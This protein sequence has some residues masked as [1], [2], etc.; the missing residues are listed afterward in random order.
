[1]SMEQIC[2]LITILVYLAGMLYIGFYCTKKGGSGNTGDFYLGGRQPV[3]YTH[4][5][6]YKRQGKQ[7]IVRSIVVPYNEAANKR[8]TDS[9]GENGTDSTGIKFLQKN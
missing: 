8:M 4:L 7:C 5:D 2:I 3:S 6:V 9:G 1:M